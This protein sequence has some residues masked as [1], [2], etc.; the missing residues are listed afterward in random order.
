V[1]SLQKCELKLAF[2]DHIISSLA[3][4]ANL[5]VY[6]SDGIWET[7]KIHKTKFKINAIFSIKMFKSE[8]ND[9]M[10]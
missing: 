2:N 3:N 6:S 10:N 5:F 4:Y 8:T 9:S 7:M 1:L